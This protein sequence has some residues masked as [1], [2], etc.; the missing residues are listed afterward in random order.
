M[1]NVN[2]F[3]WGT[4]RKCVVAFG[5]MFNNIYVD[6]FDANDVP[7]KTLKVPLAYAPKQKFLAKIDQQPGL[8]EEVNFEITI[9]RMSFEMTGMFYDGERKLSLIQQNRGINESSTTLNTQYVPVPYTLNFNLYVYSKNISD[10]HQII[11][12]ILPFFNPDYNLSVKAVPDLNL[13]H[14]VNIILNSVAFEDTYE[15]DFSSRR[16]IIWTL[17]FTVKTNFYGPIKRQGLI[18]S[19]ITNVYHSRDMAT[20]NLLGNITVS[21]SPTTAMPDD[22][23]NIEEDFEGFG[24]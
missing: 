14:D 19:T 10:S 18:K 17:S 4:M 7:E 20:A 11:E 15:G 6:R 3:Y 2:K 8:A 24:E 22:N 23:F 13:N 21:V 5:N 12:Q 1:L 16:M 9:P